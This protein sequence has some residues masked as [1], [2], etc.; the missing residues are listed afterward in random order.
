VLDLTICPEL[1]GRADQ[2]VSLIGSGRKF[3]SMAGPAGCGK[4]E[5]I[6]YIVNTYPGKV[7]VA[8][9]MG[10]AAR[11]LQ[12]RGIEATTI[13]RLVFYPLNKRREEMVRIAAEIKR[14]K[15]S[16]VIGSRLISC[17]LDWRC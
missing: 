1:R 3:V 6:K 15:S 2:A 8:A 7:C 11:M 10:Q 5:A 17:T 13:H 14:L 4:T 9:Y 12:Q 16:A